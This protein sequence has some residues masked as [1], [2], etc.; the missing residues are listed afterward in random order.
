MIAE[1]TGFGPEMKGRVTTH[2]CAGGTLIE[3][4]KNRAFCRAVFANQGKTVSL[5]E[6]LYEESRTDCHKVSLFFTSLPSIPPEA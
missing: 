1:P 5:T 4:S 6:R 2:L 3:G